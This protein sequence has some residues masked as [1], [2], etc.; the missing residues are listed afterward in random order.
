[1]SS[2]SPP[3][4]DAHVHLWDLSVRD[5]PWTTG[6]FAPLHRSFALG[7]VSGD[8]ARAAV[9]GVVLVQ[10]LPLL[11][12]TRE[13][14][15]TAAGDALVKGVVGWIDLTATNVEEELSALKNG[16]WGDQLVGIRHLVQSETDARWL[17]RDDVRSGLA[18]VAD[19][20]LV[21]D[22]LILGAQ[23]PAAVETVAALPQLQFILDHLAKPNI[24]SS[25]LEPWGTGIR[26]LASLPNAAC[27]LSGMV[28]EA[29]WK[30]WRVEDLR[31]YAE[32]ALDAFG[33]ER[34]LFGSDWPVCTLA[35]S[36]T[37]V[38]EA[39]AQL[40]EHMTP[41]ERDAVFGGNAQRLYNVR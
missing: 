13:L 22:L 14:L 19:A 12:E 35:A 5:Q 21:Y 28:T 2:G 34:M 1:M 4:I 41:S 33:V 26:A 10:A 11:D 39:A 9:D 3:R 16:P 25:G 36:Y 23:L 18:A 29:D 38:V 30:L 15:A 24:S 6:A 7:D 40:T 8:L 27:K 20:G 37:E 31:P 17:C 32:L